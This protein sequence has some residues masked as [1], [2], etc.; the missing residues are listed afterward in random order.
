MTTSSVALKL[1]SRD[2]ITH[3]A[4]RQWTWASNCR[5][6]TKGNRKPSNRGNRLAASTT[7]IAVTLKERRIDDPK[8]VISCREEIDRPHTLVDER[9]QPSQHGLC[10]HPALL[11]RQR[12]RTWPEGSFARIQ[13]PLGNPSGRRESPSGASRSSVRRAI[14]GSRDRRDVADERFGLDRR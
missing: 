9:H 6:T 5:R 8:T 3:R 4:K 11:D 12:T 10:L 7:V 1:H 2:S 13:I 14:Y